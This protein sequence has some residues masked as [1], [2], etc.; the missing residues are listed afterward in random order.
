LEDLREVLVLLL[1]AQDLQ[2]LHEGQAGVDHDRELARED[3]QVLRGD[4][5]PELRE[6]YLLALLLDRRDQDL[7]AAQ[8]GHHRFLVLRVAFPGHHLAVPGL[9][10]PDECRHRALLDQR[11]E[12]ATSGP[13]DASAAGLRPG[14]WPG[15]R[16]D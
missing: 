2:A 5:A 3:G 16:R 6:R 1:A 4:A 7:V 12:G 10:L 8:E 9:A 11:P 15:R 13:L 14:A